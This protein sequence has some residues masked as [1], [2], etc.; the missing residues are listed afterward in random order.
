MPS[1]ITI[2][3]RLRLFSH[4]PGILLPIPYSTMALRLF[5]TR[6][7]LIDEKGSLTTA[8]DL[9]LSGP[10]KNFT[11][12]LDL[13]KARLIGFGVAQEGFFRY[14]IDGNQ[15]VFDRA[16]PSFHDLGLKLPLPFD[17][18]PSK[19]PL[20]RLSLGMS[21]KGEWEGIRKRR[22]LSEIF[23]LWL[24]LGAFMPERPFLYPSGTLKFLKEAEETLE[25]RD[26][27]PFETLFM[28]GF[29]GLFVPRV[30]DK[31]HLGFKIDE[32]P[33]DQSP[34]PILTHGACLIR[35]FFIEEKEGIVSLLPHLPSRFMSG[36]FLR[37]AV[38]K[39]LLDMEW[40]KG[41]LRR[42]NFLALKESELLLKWPKDVHEVRLNGKVL[43]IKESLTTLPLT[44][45]SN[46]CFDCLK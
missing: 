13:E 9:P 11:A 14:Y 37:I 40:R 41:H 4:T 44:I 43:S 46:Y 22:D 23:P 2:R 19:I 28:T 5:P 24:R 21:K 17:V 25:K 10:I 32:R 45:D 1:K 6:L 27:K 18:E 15:L 16:P 26:L 34:Y 12:S 31:E 33:S 8:I 29:Q 3:E 36:R 35:R 20:E 39:G 38:E 30:F 42:V 7:E